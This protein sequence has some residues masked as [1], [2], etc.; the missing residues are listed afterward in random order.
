MNVYGWI[1]VTPELPYP[2]VHVLVW[3]EGCKCMFM[4]SR[5]ANGEWETVSDVNGEFCPLSFTPTLFRPLPCTPDGRIQYRP[6][7]RY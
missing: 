6:E 3:R 5:M 4:A 7:E 1:E 2:N